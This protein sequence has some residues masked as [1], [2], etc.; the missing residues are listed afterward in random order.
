MAASGLD[1]YEVGGA[2]RDALLGLP[3]HD[4]DWVVVGTTPERMTELGFRPVGRDFPVFL[5]PDTHEEYALARTERKTGRGYRGFVVQCAP[6]VTLEEDLHRRDLTIN[7]MAR[8]ADGSIVD[9]WGGGRDLRDGVLRHVSEAFAEDPVRILRVARFAAR[10][11]RFTVAPET[12]E[13]M[14][15]MVAAGEVD[16]LVPERV[17][18]E[19]SRGLMERRPSRMLAVLHACGALARLVPELDAVAHAARAPDSA[20]PTDAEACGLGRVVDAAAAAGDPLPV[21]VAALALEPGAPIAAAGEPGAEPA[22]DADAADRARRIAER[23]KAPNEGR[24]L[25]LIAARERRVLHEVDALDAAQVVALFERCDAMRKPARFE[26]VLRACDAAATAAA[27]AGPRLSGAD[28]RLRLAL[29]AARSID[30]GA[31]AARVGASASGGPAAIGEALRAARIQAIAVVF[32]P[33]RA[34]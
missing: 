30:A 32:G 10:F 9:P 34:D 20:D 2:V 4:R 22:P 11:E 23:L 16:A 6:E 1:C 26:G 5:H 28:S 31:I 14:R 7:A 13:L 15:T 24:E 12:F 19:V 21:R 8:A 17:W 29:D 33:D 27:D 3:V 18:Q 25:A